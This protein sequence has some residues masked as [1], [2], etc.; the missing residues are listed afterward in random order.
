[1]TETPATVAA[2]RVR[3]PQ[4]DGAFARAG[5]QCPC[6]RDRQTRA[7]RGVNR[8][9]NVAATTAGKVVTSQQFAASSA[10]KSTSSKPLRPAVAMRLARAKRATANAAAPVTKDA[11]VAQEVDVR[12]YDV[13]PPAP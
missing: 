10:A 6:R 3:A 9:A 2:K 11:L 1:M 13:R 4:P 8:L 5:Q 7:R 12:G